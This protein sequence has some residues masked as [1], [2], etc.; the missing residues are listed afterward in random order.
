MKDGSDHEGS[1]RA[2][3]TEND[4][5]NATLEQIWTILLKTFLGSEQTRYVKAFKRF[6]LSFVTWPRTETSTEKR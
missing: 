5:N 6:L 4:A 2:E 3:N 1:F